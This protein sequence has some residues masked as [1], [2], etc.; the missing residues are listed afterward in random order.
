MGLERSIVGRF[1]STPQIDLDRQIARVRVT[2]PD[3]L[4]FAWFADTMVRNNIGVGGFRLYARAR[5]KKGA[6]ILEPTGQRFAL[7]GSPPRE[8]L[9]GLRWFEVRDWKRTDGATLD[10][11]DP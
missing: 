10:P 2:R 9:P 5:I 11:V 7:S 3:K 1:G 4:D 8:A 6:V